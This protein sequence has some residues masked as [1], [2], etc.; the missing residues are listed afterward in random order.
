MVVRKARCMMILKNWMNCRFLYKV[1]W[2]GVRKLSWLSVSGAAVMALWMWHWR[3][4]STSC[5]TDGQSDL[6]ELGQHC[7]ICVVHW[8][9]CTMLSLGSVQVS[10]ISAT[11]RCLDSI[12]CCEKH[13]RED[14]IQRGGNIRPNTLLFLFIF[15]LRS[16]WIARYLKQRVFCRFKFTPAHNALVGLY[17]NEMLGIHF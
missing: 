5:V 7:K 15:V 12:S 4:I 13:V 16:L 3:E 8:L 1:T 2:Y 11:R 6:Q 17:S 10:R 14:E 9:D